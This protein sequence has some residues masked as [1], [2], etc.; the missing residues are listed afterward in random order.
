MVNGIRFLSITNDVGD[1]AFYADQVLLSIEDREAL[2]FGV[3]PNPFKD[4]LTLSLVQG[5][6]IELQV[7]NLLGKEVFQQK[8]NSQEIYLENLSSGVYFLKAYTDKGIT[9]KKIIKMN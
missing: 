7:Y 3:Y 6:I 2:E 9:T 5:E 8:G 1:Q 4:R